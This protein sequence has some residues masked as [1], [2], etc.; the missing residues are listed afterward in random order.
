MAVL[1]CAVR[2]AS[3]APEPN[4][5]TAD[6]VWEQVGEAA[7][8]AYRAGGAEAALLHWRRALT[9]ARDRFDASDP[10]LGTSLTNYAFGLCRRGDDVPARQHFSQAG[11]VFADSWRWIG[12]MRPPGAPDQ[13]Y[14]LAALSTFGRLA[15]DLSRRARAIEARDELPTG[16]LERWRSE[17][18]LRGSDLRKL[19][20]A[21]FLLVSL[22][23]TD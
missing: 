10:R 9:I 7:V 19:I 3:R 5:G 2:P 8:C 11:C 16:G 21:S 20:G 4:F 17:R 15:R 1:E 18:P 12:R 22:P 23:E 6:L 13:A 14:D